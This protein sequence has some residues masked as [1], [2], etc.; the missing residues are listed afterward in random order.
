MI[1]FLISIILSI[2]I[3]LFFLSFIKIENV[4]KEKVEKKTQIVYVKKKSKNIIKSKQTPKIPSSFID[5]KVNKKTV[6]S[7]NAD[8]K[9][10]NSNKR[11]Y[12]KEYKKERK[13]KVEEKSLSKEEIE[14]IKK[15][16]ILRKNPYFKDWS[17]DRIKKL[18]LP[19]GMKDWDEVE[20]LTNYLD[21]QYNWIYTPP[22]LGNDSNKIIWKDFK[23][24]NNL[25]IRFLFE[26]IF[27]IAEFQDDKNTISVTYFNN[28][29]KINENFDLPENIKDEDIKS[30]EFEITVKISDNDKNNTINYYINQIIE[31]Y[32]NIKVEENK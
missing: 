6:I 25:Q 20:K 24:N 18:E 21:N 13:I 31:Y 15:I 4:K 7:P 19:P 16:Q 28:K 22:N 3:H 5:K 11:T 30:F 10:I 23:I 9:S 14:M 29:S 32:K 12:K 8:S 2:L 17:D 26:N 27:F 1:R